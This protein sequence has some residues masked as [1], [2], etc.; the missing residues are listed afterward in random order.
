MP[1]ITLSVD[2]FNNFIGKDLKVSDLVEKLPWLGLDIE[3]VGDDYIKVEYTPNRP[4]MGAPVGIARAFEGLYL[5]KIGMKKYEVKS[6][7]LTVYVDSSVANIRP[8]LVSCVVKDIKMDED[9]LIEIINLQED[10]HQ[11]LGRERR[12]V[13]IGIHNFDVIHFPVR[14]TTVSNEFRFI[15]LDM[16]YEMSIKSILDEHPVGQKY[17]HLVKGFKRYPILIDAEGNVLSFPPV[18]NSEYTRVYENTRNLFLDVTATDFNRAIDVLNILATTLADYGGK[19]HSVKV[20]YEAEGREITTPDLTPNIIELELNKFI[21]L[22]TKYL[23]IQLSVNDIIKSLLKCRFNVEVIKDKKIIVKV[24]KY[25]VDIL[26][27]IDLVE[28]IAIG[29]GYWNITPKLPERY[30]VGEKHRKSRIIS[31]VVDLMV[32]LGFTEVMNYILTNPIEQ[33]EKM[34]ISGKQL[35]MVEESKS[36]EYSALRIWIIPQLLRNLYISKD[37]PYP[38]KIFEVGEVFDR[39][40]EESLHVAAAISHS[41]VGYSEIKSVLD[42]FTKRLRV[43]VNITPITHPSFIEGRVGEIFFSNYKVGIIGEIH[44]QVLYN[45]NLEM[46]VAVFEMDITNLVNSN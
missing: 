15:P 27:P 11:G 12:K 4:D 20:V 2:R 9:T 22:V 5:D 19:I 21:D 10:L 17:K 25:R 28:E 3:D 35:I 31:K 7:E 23:G 34:L 44:P 42:A 37:E 24:P 45:F 43:H 1:V 39:G 46:P 33:T 32:S 14:Y 29:Y 6:S 40:I 41:K 16:N 26:H 13:S 30:S 38:H 8:Y 18:I 36:T